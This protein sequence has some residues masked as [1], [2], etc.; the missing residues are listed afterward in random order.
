MPDALSPAE[1]GALWDFADPAASEARFRD[2]L[3]RAASEPTGELVCEVLTQIARAQGLQRRYD[4]AHATL[5][6]A[7]ARSRPERPRDAIRIAL[8]RGRVANSARTGDRGRAAFLDAWER[9]TSAREDALAVDAAHML[10]IVEEPSAAWSWNERALALAR[11]S[12]DPDAQRWVATLANNM[13]W[14]RH[15]AGAP[16]EALELFRL[17]LAERERQDD[18]RRTQIARWCVARCLR[19][20][21]RIDEA[22]AEQ[23]ALATELDAAGVVD[24]YVTE[25]RAECLLLLG[26]EDEARPL[27]AR[28]HAE[29]SADAWFAEAEPE[30]LARL[31]SLGGA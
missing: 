1:L 10:G 18:V 31:A 5:H 29:L 8:E 4:D 24:G 7:A 16:E 28:A 20:L 14:A 19:T 27:F 13:G 15:D 11:S 12:D 25:E 9:A 23:D 21:G 3:E 22:L 6:E 30:R 17:A 26:R 2:A